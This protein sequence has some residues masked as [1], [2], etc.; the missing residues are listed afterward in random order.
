VIVLLNGA[1]GIGKTAVARALARRLPWSMIFDPEKVGVPLQRAARMLGRTVDDFQDM[2]S[3]R[4]LTV[5]GL[6]A[7]AVLS[8]CLIV[9]MAFSEPRYLD[10]I[11]G[12][13]ERFDRHVHH[14]CLVAPLAVVQER[15]HARG[16]EPESH[17]WEYRR[18]AECCAAHQSDVFA[19]RVDAT[20]ET[21]DQL[22]ARIAQAIVRTTEGRAA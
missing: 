18:A 14:F 16:D 21:P 15:L 8:P 13:A 2:A 5:L 3:W 9:P 10:E 11:R 4:K 1:F 19:A 22:A 12:G 17:P 7:S 20:T 6:R